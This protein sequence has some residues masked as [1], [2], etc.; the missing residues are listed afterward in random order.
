MLSRTN[1][2][3]ALD[4][5][6]V[7][8]RGTRVV[9]SGITLIYRFIPQGGTTL[10][11]ARFAFIISTKVDKRATVRNRMRRVLSESVRHQMSSLPIPLDGIFI[12]S[13]SLIGLSQAQ[14]E[15][16]VVDVFS[17]VK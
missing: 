11:K 16:R 12:G 8:K 14:V 9:A 7:M 13:K 6:Q 5:P 2:L 3:P 15:E 17:K 10:A 4:I 1:R